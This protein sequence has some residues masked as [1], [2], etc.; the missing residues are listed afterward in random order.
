MS[1]VEHSLELT[2][3]SRGRLEDELRHLSRERSDILDQLNTVLRQKNS[4]AEES[5]KLRHELD[6]QV[7]IAAQM[8]RDKEN[9]MKE[10]AELSVHVTAA[11]RESRRLGEVSCFIDVLTE[12]NCSH[13]YTLLACSSGILGW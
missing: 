13:T 4:L 8:S 6:R 2:E 7:D 1:G 11:E 12:Y 5:V 10:K 9:L 3:Q